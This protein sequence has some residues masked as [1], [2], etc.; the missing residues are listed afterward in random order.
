[1]KAESSSH[2]NKK[3]L[4]NWY[5]AWCYFAVWT[6]YSLT[7]INTAESSGKNFRHIVLILQNAL[8]HK[9]LC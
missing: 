6:K 5:M 2:E 4:I 7:A 3:M 1:M 9:D 8:C